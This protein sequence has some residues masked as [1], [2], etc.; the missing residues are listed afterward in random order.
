[1]RPTIHGVHLDVS[2]RL[3]LI[4]LPGVNRDNKILELVT[5]TA[6][7]ATLMAEYLQTPDPLNGKKSVF[8]GL[9]PRSALLQ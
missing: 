2:W 8:G 4:K 6:D 5:G 7:F 9:F 3:Q 1:M